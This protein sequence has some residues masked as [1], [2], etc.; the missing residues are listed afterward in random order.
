MLLHDR[1]WFPKHRILFSVSGKCQRT[2]CDA[3][4]NDGLRVCLIAHLCTVILQDAADRRRIDRKRS[5]KAKKIRSRADLFIGDDRIHD[6]RYRI[7]L[8]H[9]AHKR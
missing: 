7:Q 3:T 1:A 8:L 4:G 6:D 2:G 5:R 9:I